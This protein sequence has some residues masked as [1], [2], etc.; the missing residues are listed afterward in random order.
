DYDG[1]WPEIMP[2]RF[3]LEGGETLSGSVAGSV[4][5]MQLPAGD[6]QVMRVASAIARD[7]LD[8]LGPWRSL[9]NT[10]RNDHDVAEAAADGA[11]WGL[12]P[13]EQVTLVHAVNRPI[14][15]PRPI[16]AV[17]IRT[18]GATSAILAGAVELHGPSTGTLTAE[19]RWSEMVDDLTLPGV[20]E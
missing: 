18:E 16:R 10:I 7:K 9:P 5:T 2:Y 6:T 19:A 11:I 20:Q 13:F 3:V 12:S 15:V 4:I 14:A 1:T 8:L 17:P